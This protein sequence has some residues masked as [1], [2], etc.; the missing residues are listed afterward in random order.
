MVSSL[1]NKPSLQRGTSILK[2]KKLV[3]DDRSSSGD[4]YAST[5]VSPTNSLNLKK[6]V[7][8]GSL[9]DSTQ[10]LTTTSSSYS[11][12]HLTTT[13][14][15]SPERLIEMKKEWR[16]TLNTNMPV[17]KRGISFRHT[18]ESVLLEE[19][20][21]DEKFAV[22]SIEIIRQKVKAGTFLN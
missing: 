12:P 9:N 6:Q 18:N 21:I 8:F 5:P 15:K 7:S 1:S 16:R 19:K 4:E 22:E 17:R 14:L 10:S 20:Y 2:L 11:S 13:D 3:Y